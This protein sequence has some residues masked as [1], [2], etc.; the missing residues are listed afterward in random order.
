MIGVERNRNLGAF[1][2]ATPRQVQRAE[3]GALRDLVAAAGIGAVPAVVAAERGLPG[4]GPLLFPDG[5]ESVGIGAVE[6]RFLV[7]PE[8]DQLQIDIVGGAK[9]DAA[10]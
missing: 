9:A 1:V 3:I 5:V 8:T 6:I 7:L 2:Q 10:T 4:I